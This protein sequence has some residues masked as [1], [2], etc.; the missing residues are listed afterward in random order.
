VAEN[1]KHAVAEAYS[2]TWATTG[3]TGNDND[4]TI[5]AAEKEQAQLPRLVGSRWM[6]E[7]WAGE[8]P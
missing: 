3:E 4:N 7:S 2:F 5:T 6:L 1:F 8:T